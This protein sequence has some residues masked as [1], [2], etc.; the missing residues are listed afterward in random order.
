MQWFFETFCGIDSAQ[1]DAHGYESLDADANILAHL[2]GFV[3]PYDV[4]ALMM[5]LPATA[6]LF[7]R[8]PEHAPHMLLLHAADALPVEPV[9]ELLRDVFHQVI[10]LTS[11][12]AAHAQRVGMSSWQRDRGERADAATCQITPIG[13]AGASEAVARR[14]RAPSVHVRMATRMPG[15]L[16]AATPRAR[17]LLAEPRSAALHDGQPGVSIALPLDAHAVQRAL[18]GALECALER[19]RTISSTLLGTGLFALLGCPIAH[20][21]DSA[22]RR[23][24]GQTTLARLT[25]T[26]ADYVLRTL[27]YSLGTSIGALLCNLSVQ[28]TAAHRARARAILCIGVGIFALLGGLTVLPDLLAL[29]ATSPAAYDG[30]HVRS[31]APLNRAAYWHAVWCV[32]GAL[33]VAQYVA[34]SCASLLGLGR[35][36][37]SVRA[38]LR[39]HWRV[40]AA[41]LLANCALEA[42]AFSRDIQTTHDC[43]S[44]HDGTRCWGPWVACAL[45]VVECAIA[46]AMLMPGSRRTARAA[47]ARALVRAQR[48]PP[49][50]DGRRVAPASRA[51]WLASAQPIA[52]DV[53][54]A[55]S[56][57]ARSSC[58]ASS[59]RRASSLPDLS[60]S[61]DA[62]LPPRAEPLPDAFLA[63]L[64]GFGSGQIATVET[65][66][67]EAARLFLPEPLDEA[68][69]A[70]LHLPSR[71]PEQHASPRGGSVGEGVPSPLERAS[72]IDRV[73]RSRNS[74]ADNAAQGNWS[75]LSLRGAGGGARRVSTDMA[76]LRLARP[77]GC[78]GLTCA[79]LRRA[80]PASSGA[81][82]VVNGSMRMR[83][84][85]GR[86]SR[87]GG[88]EQ[89]A[90]RTAL[91]ASGEGASVRSCRG[92]NNAAAAAAA[93]GGGTLGSR[94]PEPGS[95]PSSGTLTSRFARGR[96][97]GFCSCVQ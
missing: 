17:R 46:C 88:P 96:N 23:A 40:L 65:V 57:T 38:L 39:L 16:V 35:W 1:F 19:Q 92:P 79:Q 69:L 82:L 90:S 91:V 71:A 8:Q 62:A 83:S 56:C 41:W 63:A 61:R 20:I 42:H 45:F 9:I 60:A 76:T 27:L 5:V 31:E 43:R 93:V 95:A 47:I 58:D 33:R 6:H 51:A 22:I 52:A 25:D 2:N 64:L 54:S 68:T 14:L 55:S 81:G 28:P 70:E 73:V 48:R 53:R 36:W 32:H 97:S 50:R 7:P 49:A 87:V 59:A 13:C 85:G 15:E 30:P 78:G 18:N 37:R 94:L 29:L 80:L 77:A 12:R 34:L 72:S 4:V 86:L 21:A 66:V 74:S 3:K 89:G 67:S 84:R 10:T 44:T 11:A 75:T 24:H 26:D